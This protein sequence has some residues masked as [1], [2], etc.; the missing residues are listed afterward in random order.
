MIYYL[1]MINFFLN[2]KFIIKIQ[3][4]I[5]KVI[6]F[7]FLC[8]NKHFHFIKFVITKIN[9]DFKLIYNFLLM[10]LFN[11]FMNVHFMLNYIYIKLFLFNEE[12]LLYIDLLSL[13]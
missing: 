9:F 11:R 4:Y 3:Y 6:H 10:N 12:H 2:F 8:F 1:I 5:L 7:L 13:F